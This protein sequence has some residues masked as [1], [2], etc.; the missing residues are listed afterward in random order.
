MAEFGA[1]PNAENAAQR[2]P[3][4]G[5]A[6][7][8]NAQGQGRELPRQPGV[9][10]VP[11][12]T[13]APKYDEDGGFDL[14]KARLESYLRQRDCWNVVIGDEG[15]DAVNADQNRIFEERNLFARNALLQG[16]LSKDAK[17][18]CKLARVSEM[19]TSFEQ[20]KTKRDFANS[21]RVR[22]KLY[23]A[24]F[25]KGRNMDRYLEELED[26]RRQLENMNTAISD[27]EMASI[28]LTG[29]EGT[30]R[31]LVR[32]FNRDDNPP[33]LNQVLNSLRS[34]AEMDKAEED[35]ISKNEIEG[36]DHEQIG[37]MKKSKSKRPWKMKK[38][39]KVSGVQHDN[40]YFDD[41]QGSRSTS[42]GFG[43]VR[44]KTLNGLDPNGKNVLLDLHE[45]RYSSC[46][47]T[48]LVS[49]ER[50][51]QDGW[52]PS[53]PPSR[54]PEERITY[55]SNERY[56]GVQLVFKKRRGH[57][58]LDTTPVASTNSICAASPSPNQDKL[59]VW[60]MRFGH[61]NV[62]AIKKM[63]ELDMVEG[64]DTLT[65]ADFKKPF[66]CIAC[67]RAK[68]KRMA[69]KRQ[70]EKRRKECYRTLPGA[71]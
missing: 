49:Q 32:I 24:R 54:S 61:L 14:F 20:D 29:V 44:G 50:L 28:I 11:G 22:A 47:H 67:Q 15:P 62:Q 12:S 7:G 63:I 48:N 56:P 18:I 25:E 69:C 34:E 27:N 4:I 16:L 39:K 19:W 43:L 6:A 66:R 5:Q 71:A 53:I 57:Y 3:Q 40:E 52:V 8:N 1:L 17:K 10:K 45:T 31:N 30:H 51:E 59:L 35:R 58:W 70:Q 37:S 46:G 68:Q 9:R 55:F 2:A 21:I 13:K 64:M 36:E 38:Q 26:Y 42:D 33:T 65:L 41:W 60:H 23:G